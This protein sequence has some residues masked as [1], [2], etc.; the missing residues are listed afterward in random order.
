MAAG[1]R[2]DLV[3]PDQDVDKIARLCSMVS[4]LSYC[5]LARLTHVIAQGEASISQA[6]F[7]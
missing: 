2:S 5:R 3:W 7:R 6:L 4:R 1:L